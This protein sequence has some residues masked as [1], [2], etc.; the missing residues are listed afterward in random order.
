M[1]AKGEVPMVDAAIFADTG[2]EQAAV[3]AFL[4]WLETR[5]PFPVHRVSAGNLR[6]DVVNRK[7]GYNPIPAY[8]DTGMGRRQCTYQY[9]LRPLRRKMRELS[10]GG[11][12]VCLV[13][14]SLDEAH[15]MKPTGLQWCVNSWPLVDLGMT[16]LD[17]LRWLSANGLPR[18][19]RSACTFCMFKRDAEWRDTKA[20]PEAWAEAVRVDEAIA[21]H[22]EYLHRS[23]KR[24]TEIDFRNAE[25]FG[26]I[27]AF[28]NE[29]EGMCGV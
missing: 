10:N 22:G 26:Q 24:L 27:D 20:D 18:P 1:I 13:G 5:L 17:C 2:A 15:R 3:Y 4:D 11:K 6:D 14:I 19:P 16:R 29:C 23:L 25:D 28:G 8:T 9:K 12:V 21:E 7:D